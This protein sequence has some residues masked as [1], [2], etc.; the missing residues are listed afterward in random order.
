VA[1]SNARRAKLRELND[2]T[3]DDRAVA[4]AQWLTAFL[5]SSHFFE[6]RH[7]LPHPSGIGRA[8]EGGTRFFFWAR[9]WYG[10]RRDD[11]DLK[12][13]NELYLDFAILADALAFGATDEFYHRFDHGF[14]W[15]CLTNRTRRAY[16]L[17]PD[18]R[19][20]TVGGSDV[21]ASLS[22]LGMIDL[23]QLEPA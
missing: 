14:F 2:A 22:S 11:A 18:R 6:A 15:N 4:G 7:S 8:Y 3:P 9:D 10:L 5:E 23:D 19:V 13:R 20:L 21:V 12:L 1:R 17:A 16:A